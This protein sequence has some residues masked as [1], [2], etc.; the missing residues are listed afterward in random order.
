MHLSHAKVGFCD[1]LQSLFAV[2]CHYSRSA[3]Q[4]ILSIL[5]LSL[6]FTDSNV[7]GELTLTT[8]AV[9]AV[10]TTATD[11]TTRRRRRRRRRRQGRWR[12]Q[13]RRAHSTI[14]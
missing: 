10:M 5:A 11:D 6:Y 12:Q 13:R 7:L 8:M 14:N 3:M 9:M 1:F 2:T 4:A